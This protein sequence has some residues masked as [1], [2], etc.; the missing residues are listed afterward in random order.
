VALVALVLGIVVPI[1]GVVA[2]VAD[3]E[4][5]DRAIIADPEGGLQIKGDLGAEGRDPRFYVGHRIKAGH[6]DLGAVHVGVVRLHRSDRKV[7]EPGGLAAGV[8]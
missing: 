6:A 8:S 1:K 4:G 7:A 5:T 2:S 3:L